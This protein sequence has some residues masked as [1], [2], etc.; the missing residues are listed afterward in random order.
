MEFL[1]PYLKNYNPV[2]V[3]LLETQ[4]KYLPWKKLAYKRS[5]T[6]KGTPKRQRRKNKQ[7]KCP[8]LAENDIP[9]YGR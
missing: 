7:Q 6:Q 8:T 9:F 2:T 5:Y 3:T 1:K 4:T